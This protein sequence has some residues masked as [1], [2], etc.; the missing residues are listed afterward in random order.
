MTDDNFGNLRKRVNER[1]QAAS[2]K[3]R[4]ALGKPPSTPRSG[5]DTHADQASLQA[6][7]A[8]YQQDMAAAV[9]ENPFTYGHETVPSTDKPAAPAGQW[10]CIVN[11]PIVSIDLVANI[12][13]DGSLSGQGTIIYVATNRVF[14]VSGK[15]DWILLPPDQSSDDWLFKFRLHPSNHAIFSWFASPTDSPNHM[16]N[17]FVSPSTGGVV[18]TRCER[19][20]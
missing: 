15:G 1:R 9:D 13:E 11:S 18:V 8:L 14:Q 16:A 19:K 17:R 2:A 5:A 10:R 3:L 7:S 6:A 20:G 12:A 4:E